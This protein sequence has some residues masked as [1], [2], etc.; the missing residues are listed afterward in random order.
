MAQIA[1]NN[2]DK[3]KGKKVRSK[4][5]ST[6]IDMTP[7]VDLAFLLLTFFM[8]ATTFNKPQTMELTVP[9][10]PKQEED[11]PLV[12]EKRVL[13][14][15]LGEQ[16]KIYWYMGIT[17]PDVQVTDYSGEGVR[18]ILLEKNQEINNLIV[19]IKP[20]DE[21]KYENLVDILD[22]MHISNVARYA[23]VDATADDLALIKEKSNGKSEL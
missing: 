20:S 1:E 13:S 15:V 2:N 12:N 10:K 11:Q 17:E 22:E 8:L 23:L 3:D 21:S 6:A 14:L 9:E 5:S 18:R 16:D 19:L 7:M 4:K